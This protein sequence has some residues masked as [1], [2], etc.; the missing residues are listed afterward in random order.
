MTSSISTFNAA[1]YNSYISSGIGSGKLYVPVKP[2]QVVYSQFEH[3]SG[4]ATRKDQSGI[5][6]T[7]IKI[8]NTL[9]DHL[10]NIKTNTP[11]PELPSEMTETQV[12]ALIK[13]YQDKI[14]TA[15]NS[16]KMTPFGLTGL[17]PPSG[18][19]VNMVA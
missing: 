4:I 1:S 19:V 16:A 10:V 7:K 13:D 17:T 18:T 15:V 5:P 9:I 2:S 8:L 11:R 3:V 14:Q 6:V 12:D